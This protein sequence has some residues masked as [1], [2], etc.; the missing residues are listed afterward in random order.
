MRT[1]R[2]VRAVRARAH[3]IELLIDQLAILAP[4]MVDK[5]CNDTDS[6]LLHRSIRNSSNVYNH[7]FPGFAC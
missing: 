4:R 6:L 1:Y 7:T 2:R 5:K 3:D